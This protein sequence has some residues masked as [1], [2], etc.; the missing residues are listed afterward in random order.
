MTATTA[1]TSTT[2]IRSPLETG[3]RFFKDFWQH[4]RVEAVDDLSAPNAIGH[5]PSGGTQRAA[6]VKAFQEAFL[7]AC[8]D[9]ELVVEDYLYS[10]TQVCLRWSAIGTHKH[11]AFG[12]VAKQRRFFVRGVT[13]MRVEEGLI[14][15]V[16]DCW[17]QTGLMKQL[18][19]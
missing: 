15:E 7:A 19:E 5:L 2:R 12:I 14:V 3:L 1:T 8:P 10:D 4:R 17:D 16:W 9:L 18:A 13:W 11:D 6:E